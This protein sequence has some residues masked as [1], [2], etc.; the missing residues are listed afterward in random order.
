VIL[1]DKFTPIWEKVFIQQTFPEVPNR[2]RMKQ[3]SRMTI[4]GSQSA[5]ATSGKVSSYGRSIEPYIT[6]FFW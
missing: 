6:Q 4:I 1:F 2:G 3:I 5:F